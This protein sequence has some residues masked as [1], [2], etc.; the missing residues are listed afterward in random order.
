M[1]KHHRNE[2]SS[3]GRTFYFE[4]LCNVMRILRST[5]KCAFEMIMRSKFCIIRFFLIKLLS[6]C[7]MFIPILYWNKRR[8]KYV[9]RV[10]EIV[11]VLYRQ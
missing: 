8:A 3:Q 9:Y 2:T 11:P 1:T 5:K 10:N 4:F 7:L 6:R